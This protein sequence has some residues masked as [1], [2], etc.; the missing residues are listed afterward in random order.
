M[1]QNTCYELGIITRP[2]GLKGEVQVYLDVD[3]PEMYS[4]LESVFVE[5]DKRLVPF[6]I[7]SFHLIGDQKAIVA[8]DDIQTL[9]Q[10]EALRGN[11]LYL[12]LKAL[13]QLEE[14]QFYFHEVI[15]YKVVDKTE[16][17]L[18]EAA[19]FNDAGAQIILIMDYMGKEVL[20]PV[21]KTILLKADH[22]N[23][24]LL[25]DLP[26]GLLDLYMNED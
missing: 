15:G 6:F 3:H 11:H 5:V 9:E 10:A 26:G 21:S 16:G 19:S 20:I 22:E 23:K 24:Q 13:P 1:N 18:G 4:E 17:E 2:H 12:P 25:V 14:D 8:F 7:E